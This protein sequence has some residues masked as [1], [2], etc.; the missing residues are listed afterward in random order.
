MWA[1]AQL[2]AWQECVTVAVPIMAGEWRTSR[3]SRQGDYEVSQ[4]CS[5]GLFFSLGAKGLV[6]HIKV[7]EA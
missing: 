1:W 6:L 5:Q 7:S 2:Q 4:A 3:S